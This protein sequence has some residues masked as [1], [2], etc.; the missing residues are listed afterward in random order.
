[1][2]SIMASQPLYLCVLSSMSSLNSTERLLPSILEFVDSAAITKEINSRLDADT[3]VIIEDSNF[4]PRQYADLFWYDSRAG[5]V[6][7]GIYR[8]IE[9][10]VQQSRS[11]LIFTNKWER[12]SDDV[13]WD[14]PHR[15]FAVFNHA[16]RF[17]GRAKSLRFSILLQ[18]DRNTDVNTIPVFFLVR[19]AGQEWL[20]EA[21]PLNQI[22]FGHS[23]YSTSAYYFGAKE[24]NGDTK[25][26]SPAKSYSPSVGEP[27]STPF[28]DGYD[29]SMNSLEFGFCVAFKKPDPSN[30]E[31]GI[32]GFDLWR[33]SR[34]I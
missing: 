20:T 23:E 22:A 8:E 2:H 13:V 12:M 15:R 3:I 17:T 29:G 19:Q 34:C 11:S 26:L 25:W 16:S 33:L 32:D 18:L 7:Y 9:A 30:F 10:Y 28:A 27:C 31:E 14:P 1:M 24:C 5:R 21:G 6:D 4:T